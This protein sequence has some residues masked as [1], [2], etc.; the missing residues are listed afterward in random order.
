MDNSQSIGT[1]D[2]PIKHQQNYTRLSM[3][4]KLLPSTKSKHRVWNRGKYRNKKHLQA[5]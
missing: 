3:K 4:S 5:V 2:K 1:K